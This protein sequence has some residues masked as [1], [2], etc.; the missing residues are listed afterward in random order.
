MDYTP[1]APVLLLTVGMLFAGLTA[2]AFLLAQASASPA[3]VWPPPPATVPSLGS[4]G[5]PAQ[6][7]TVPSIGSRR[8]APGSPPTVPSI[9]SPGAPPSPEPTASYDKSTEQSQ[10]PSVGSQ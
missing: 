4:S 6:P 7:A 1:L 5:A 9:G 2:A 3:P 8:V 10:P